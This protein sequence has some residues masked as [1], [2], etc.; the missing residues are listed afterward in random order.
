MIDDSTKRQ[1]RAIAI[2]QST[3]DFLERLRGIDQDLLIELVVELKPDTSGPGYRLKITEEPL[4]PLPFDKSPGDPFRDV[5]FRDTPW[6]DHVRPPSGE[7][8][9]ESGLIAEE[10]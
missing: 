3:A 8:G 2:R 5:P 4:P 1:D 10:R 6:H 7:S 9:E